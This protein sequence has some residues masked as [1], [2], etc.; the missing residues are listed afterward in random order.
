MLSSVSLTLRNIVLPAALGLAIVIP[1]AT[2]LAAGNKAEVRE[3]VRDIAMQ[4]RK[5]G[6]RLKGAERRKMI[7]ALG[8][9]KI[10]CLSGDVQK[11]YLAAAKLQGA[12]QQ[13]QA[14]N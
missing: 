3:C 2:A 12:P 1:H 10:T 5:A 7:V 13:A 9:V 6:I 4:E 14:A 11:A 8:K